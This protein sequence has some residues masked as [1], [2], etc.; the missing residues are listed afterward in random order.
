[1]QRNVFSGLMANRSLEG[2]KISKLDI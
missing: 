2:T 1:V